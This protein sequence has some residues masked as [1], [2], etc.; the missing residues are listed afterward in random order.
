MVILWLGLPNAFW[1]KKLLEKCVCGWCFFFFYSLQET[2][3]PWLF[4]ARDLVV[5]GAPCSFSAAGERKDGRQKE[6][7]CSS[8]PARPAGTA[9]STAPAW[10]SCWATRAHCLRCIW[11]RRRGKPCHCFIF[12]YICIFFYD[13]V[14]SRSG[15]KKE[16]P[17]LLNTGIKH[18]WTGFKV[19]Y[20]GAGMPKLYNV[21]VSLVL[22][23]CVCALW[24]NFY[25]HTIRSHYQFS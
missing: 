5:A 10:G 12:N 18:Q 2:L 24:C 17:R 11:Q 14:S 21:R 23:Y 9:G 4:A 25:L 7:V 8:C 16:V 22:P 3:S 20:L 1:C 13:E 19:R 6:V 15:A